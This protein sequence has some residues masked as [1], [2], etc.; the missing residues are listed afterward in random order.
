[1]TSSKIQIHRKYIL[2]WHVSTFVFYNIKKI[3][4]FRKQHQKKANSSKIYIF[5]HGTFTFSTHFISFT[6]SHMAH[7]IIIIILAWHISFAFIIMLLLLLHLLDFCTFLYSHMAD[8]AVIIIITLLLLGGREGAKR[9][10]DRR[11]FLF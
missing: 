9:P 3:Q 7:I 10:T 11:N 2:T 6:Y 5:T 8:T 4:I 1:M